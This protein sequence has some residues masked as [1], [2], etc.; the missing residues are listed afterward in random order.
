M[1]TQNDQELA[2]KITALLDSS[3]N[4]LRQGTAYKLQLARQA[5]LEKMARRG[6]DPMNVTSGGP[7]VCAT[8]SS[9]IPSTSCTR[10]RP[11]RRESRGWSCAP[12]PSDIGR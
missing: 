6:D 3:N 11:T 2:K 1:N 7:P 4:E 8:T 10:T 5:A 9:I 12:S